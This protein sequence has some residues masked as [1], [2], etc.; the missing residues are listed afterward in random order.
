[1]NAGERV[2]REELDEVVRHVA[3]YAGVPAAVATRRALVAA[4]RQAADDGG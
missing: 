2:R 4:R 3:A 1:M